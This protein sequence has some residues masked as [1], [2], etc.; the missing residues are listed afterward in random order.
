MQILNPACRRHLPIVTLVLAIALT[1]L[2]GCAH[3]WPLPEEE[4]LALYSP[5][6]NETLDPALYRHA[7]LFVAHASAK[8]HN[9]IGT[10][11]ARYDDYGREKIY[12]DPDKPTVYTQ[13]RR[14]R[15]ERGTYTTLVS[16]LV[17]PAIPAGINVDHKFDIQ[18]DEGRI[19]FFTG[20]G[21]GPAIIGVDALFLKLFGV[22]FW[23]LHLG[24]L[25][26]FTAYLLLAGVILLLIRG[27]SSVLLF[28]LYLFLYPQLSIFHDRS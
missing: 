13:M 6:A 27:L 15:T 14:F 26:F 16:T 7:P 8:P 21:I 3:H 28:N 22:G 25:F 12:I 11:T 24:P 18:D 20:N 23:Q 9:R 1:T 17:D 19:W 5:R 10:P 2:G 4:E